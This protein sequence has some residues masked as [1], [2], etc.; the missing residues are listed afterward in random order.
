MI[1]LIIFPLPGKPSPPIMPTWILLSHQASISNACSEGTIWF[2]RMPSPRSSDFCSCALSTNVCQSALW[3]SQ[4]PHKE[5]QNPYEKSS[6]VKQLKWINYAG[7]L[8]PLKML[9]YVVN[10]VIECVFPRFAWPKSRVFKE[11]LPG[12]A[13][14]ETNFG[15]CCCNVI[16]NSPLA[17][18]ITPGH[19]DSL[20]WTCL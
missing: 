2:C 14:R 9:M 15:K 3:E 5:K 12:L 1:L 18:L 4:G 20:L 17:K 19:F 7:L 13:F 11:H 10:W 6:H 8:R 16:W